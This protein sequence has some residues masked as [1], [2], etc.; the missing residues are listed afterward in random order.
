MQHRITDTN[1]SQLFKLF[2]QAEDFF[3]QKDW[4]AAI[5]ALKKLVANELEPERKVL[6]YLKHEFAYY[7]QPDE[8]IGSLNDAISLEQNFSKRW[9]E[10]G[11]YGLSITW[12]LKLVL[13][14]TKSK[15]YPQILAP[16]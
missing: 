9:L 10:E 8:S 6:Y 15:T 4:T 3:K 2:V 13:H 7:K 1:R 14:N 12:F 11:C 5:P 16:S